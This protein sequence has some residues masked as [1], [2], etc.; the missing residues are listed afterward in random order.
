[1][2][3]HRTL[4]E[5][6]RG[7]DVARLHETL[8]AIGIELD[9]DERAGKQFGPHTRDAVTRIQLVLGL[10]PTGTV[11]PATLE[12][13]LIARDRL[14]VDRVEPADKPRRYVVEGAVTDA[15][16]LPLTGVTV[17][18]YR[19]V[20]RDE[21]EI[22]RAPAD[23]S[24]RYHIEYSSEAL[25]GA[26]PEAEPE[27]EPE[28]D[29]LALRLRVLDASGKV[30]FESGVH[31]HVSRREQI[32]LAVGG[33]GRAEPAEFHR[34]LGA[35]DA[36]LRHMRLEELEESGE[37]RDLTFLGDD[38][39]VGRLAV[40]YHAIAARLAA[41]T[42]LPAELFYALFRENVPADAAVRALAEDAEGTNLDRNAQRLLDAVLSATP[43]IRAKAVA[44]AIEAGV[45]AP[46][47]AE[48]AQDDL[49]RL[50]SHAVDAALAASAGMGKTPVSDVLT[51]AAKVPAD[52]QRV[53]MERWST[54]SGPIREFWSEL[55]DSKAFTTEE[56]A[57]LQFAMTVGRFT[58]GHLPLVSA[59]ADMRAE[60]EITDTRDLARLDAADWRNLIEGGDGR[61][62]VGLPENFTAR[63]DE[64]AL[65]AYTRLL[66]R[67]FERA[68]PTVAF[69]ARLAADA[70]SPFVAKDAVVAFLDAN[71]EFD[72]RKTN[73]DRYLMDKP[74]ALEGDRE[75]VR[76][77]LLTSQRL[78]KLAPR[79]GAAKPLLEAGISSAQ[80]IYSMGASRFQATY[81]P[82]PEIGE[83][84]A[85]RIYSVA[86]QTYAM[87]LTLATQLGATIREINP[88]AIGHPAPA[89][90]APAEG[91]APADAEP[92][93]DLEAFPN[94]RTLFGSLDLC[95]CKHCRSVLSPAAHLTDMLRFLSH[96]V[97]A[98]TSAKQVLLERRP[99]I[100]QIELSCENTNTVLP[101]IDLVN[102]L[103]EDA[104]ASPPDLAAAARARQTTLET[105]ELNANPQY[106]NDGA[107]ATLAAAV[108]PWNLPFDLPLLEAR[109]YLDRLGTDRVRLMRTVRKEPDLG[110]AE[111]SRMAVEALGLSP[112]E[113]DIVIAGPLAASHQPWDYW[114]LA[115]SGN[116]VQDPVETTR[117]YTGTWLEVLSNARILLDRARLTHAELQH[118]LN[119]RF[120]NPGGAVTTSDTCDIGEMT[121]G[122]LT[123]DVL[124][125][126]HRFVR[127]MRRLGWTPNDL[128]AAI[129]QLQGSTPAGAGRLNA[130]LLRQLRAVTAA[131]RRFRI[132]APEAIALLAGIDT[133]AVPPLPGE[134]APRQCLYDQLFQ[135]PAVLNPVD[136][137]FELD[138]ARQEID[139]IAAN[140][141]LADHR[142][143]LVAAF[144]LPDA[145][146]GRAIAEETDGKLTLANL[147][148][149]YRTVLLARGLGLTVEELLVLRDIAEMERPAAPGY[150]PIDPF[151][152]ARPELLER[153]CETVDTV[154]DADLDI[155]QLDYLLRHRATPKSGVALDDVV[156]GTL[157][158][159]MREGLVRI[160]GENAP[161]ADPTGAQVR[162]RL[163]ALMPTAEVEPIMAILAGTSALTEVNQRAAVAGSLG[164]FVPLAEAQAKLVGAAALAA[165]TARYEYVFGALAVHA[166][167]T[168]GT[169]LIVQQLAEA[170][171]LAT[172][173][174]R[175]L[176][177]GWFPS[178]TLP[179]TPMLDQFLLL[180]T[181]ARDPAKQQAPV[182]RD[183]A[184][185]ADY[186]TAYTA[187][188][189]AARLIS[190][191]GFS[192]DEVAWFQGHGVAA[193]WLDP[194]TLPAT[195]TP[196]PEGRF[197]RWLRVA[198]AARLKAAIPGDGGAFGGL[199]DVAAG[200]TKAGHLETIGTRMDWSA[201]DL[202]ALAG[203]RTDATN[204]GLL[205]LAFPDD[206]RSE[207]ALV[208]LRRAFAQLRRLGVPA[209][210]AGEWTG[211]AVSAAQAAAIKQSVKAKYTV[212]QWPEI[213][214]PVRD[215]L[216]ERQRDALVSFLLTDPPP[217]VR[218]WQSPNDV[219]GHYLIDV[220]M[221]ACQ[222]TSRIV[223]ANA[224]IQLFVQRSAL[225]LEPD[226]TVDAAADGHWLEWKWM[227]RYRVWEANRKVFLYPENWIEPGL[228]RDK[229]PFFQDMENELLQGEVTKGTAEA[230][231]RGYL[232]K[233]DAVARL[234]VLGTYFEAG[235]PNR[236]HVIGRKQ[237]DPPT[238]YHR[239]WVDSSR[240]TAW[241]RVELD[242]VSDH[243]LPVAWN[244]R[245]YLFWA[246]VNRRADKTQSLP[247]LTPANSPPPA[248][249]FHLEAQLAWS[250]L[251][252]GKW[253]AKQTAPQTFVVRRDAEPRSVTL[254]SSI[255][256]PL[257]RIDVF[258]ETLHVVLV[259]PGLLAWQ[260]RDHVGEFVLGGVGNSVEAFAVPGE[261]LDGAG[262]G[263]A[264]IGQ[265]APA[266]G[267]GVLPAPTNSDYDGM[268]L[269]PLGT[270]SGG[271][272]RQ[273]VAPC[274]TTYD[275][276]GTLASET[277][278]DRADRY[279]LLIPHQQLRFDSSLPFFYSD[280]QRSYFVIPQRYYQNGN[281]FLTTAPA[282]VYRPN[283]R[284]QYKFAPNYHAFVPLLIRELN[285]GGVDRLY[286]RRLQASP[287]AAQGVPAFDFRTYYQPTDRV[288]APYP[289]EGIDFDYDA[290]YSIYNWEL[291]FHAP[292]QIG[293]SLS[294]N[295]RF[296]EA[297]HFYEYVFDPTSA[298]DEPAPQR[299]WVTKR[300]HD[301]TA[302]EYRAAEIRR[303]MALINVRDPGVEHQVA[304]WR[305]NPFE[306]HV[307]AGLRPVAYQRAIVMKYID[308]LIAW[309]D[310][311]FRQDTMDSVN[312]ATQL[313][314]LAAELLGPRPEIVQPARDVP[315][316]Y[317]DIEAGL[318]TFA[319]AA[320]AAA[321]NAIAPVQVDVAT[322]QG[323]P[324]L[325][326][327]PPL[328]FCVPP[329]EKL[330]AYWDTVG[331]RL[332]KIRHCMNIEGV[333]RQLTLFAPP[334][335]PGL[336]VKAAAAGLDLGSL[337]SDSGSSLPPYRFRVMVREAMQITDSV[338]MLG[339]E[340]LFALEKRDAEKLTL[341]RS[342]SERTLH[343]GL[344]DMRKKGADEAQ[345]QI[346][347]LAK[348]REVTLERQRYFAERKDDLT[349]DWEAAA[350]VLMGASAAAQAVAL[351]LDSASGA[352]HLIPEVQA[353]ASG[354]GGS[355]H[356][357]VK[358]GGP[359]VG[360]G[361]GGFA[362]AA[363]V[364]AALLQTGA[365]MSSVLGGY[366]RRKQEA[367]FQHGLAGKELAVIQAQALTLTIRKTMAENEQANE[368]VVRALAD[369]T[370][371]F[372][373][374]RFTNQELYEW[375]AQ[376]TSATY[377]Q[378]YRLAYA[379]AQQAEACFRRE[380]GV[381][382]TS[383]VQFGYWDSLKK[384]LLAGDKLGFD[385]E[386]METAY[387]SADTRELELTK[388][389]SLLQ[390]D[391]V[392]LVELRTKGECIVTL[393][394]LL[395]DLETPGHYMR[396]LKSVA[397]T[398]P[399][400]TGPYGNVS[401]TATLLDNHVRTSPSAAAPY[402]RA[403]GDDARFT[404]DS[405]GFSA[406]VTSSGQNDPGLFE[407]NHHDERY[408]PFEGAGAIGT[409]KLR[410]NAV[411]PP[412]DYRSISDVIL[413]LRYTARD[414][415]APLA[416][417]AAG[418]VRT[419]LNAVVLAQSRRGLYKLV[420]PKQ[421][422]ASQWHAFLHP[423]VGDDQRLAFDLAPDRFPFFSHGLDLK[424]T[425]IDIYAKLADAGDYSL[426]IGRPGA[427]DE[428][429]TLEADDELGGVHHWGRHPLAPKSGLGRAPATAPHEFSLK[430]KRAGAADF[431]SLAP[432]EVADLSIVFQY[433]A[434]P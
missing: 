35:I 20:L 315:K 256:D 67:S 161:A 414:G 160:A 125:R 397:I 130:L 109:T 78:L 362:K 267:K 185:F 242:I 418:A 277:V 276:Y 431:R 127:L 91:S 8:D 104:V 417:A 347:A 171:S 111:T 420:S 273:R 29:R 298:V 363:K 334:I 212:D 336:L 223:Q 203:D 215:V 40:A 370:D 293:E 359:N 303:L 270:T 368:D 227:S 84:E 143:T 246:I 393:P 348:S 288:I 327:F 214:K 207:R 406:I 177:G 384:G 24:G 15:D 424:V 398:V 412:F 433:E 37:H 324:Q 149:L 345:K 291:F 330:L 419:Q 179:A 258:A 377:F 44:T 106:V 136:A 138:A 46:S 217:G 32:P 263:T 63:D 279:R 240:W 302:P 181:V 188:D 62:P 137:M 236:L 316:T 126:L 58:R 271:S 154:R 250:E 275:Q 90:P 379:V 68:Y 409:W 331:D 5:G 402:M 310:Q 9:E 403:A 134:D 335:D 165:G 432:D 262:P 201:E 241:T 28:A 108:H 151:D 321:E 205:G 286:E 50:A 175:L 183:E 326:V 65:E 128:D 410:L 59:I 226:V 405:G 425:G 148:R 322:P 392:A 260:S 118:V 395:F 69:S 401:L 340:L 121:V 117:A 390:M 140:P 378:A 355:P 60:G 404:D 103:L 352:A 131:M 141:E 170:L 333:I 248:T 295:Q 94:L 224:S 120:V 213:A 88:A 237:G 115:E 97:T 319:N 341:I 36:R 297:K 407:L 426:A 87:A 416:D 339:N 66:E 190:G 311:L 93:P 284:A 38:A 294:L 366:Q 381:K 422:L 26:R 76:E 4:S 343:K 413:H 167:R 150:E 102:E 73:V 142:D 6:M 364:V 100:A 189:K 233:L 300:F 253:Q 42:E 83:A 18:A 200:T 228:R 415:G 21:D 342:S 96:R 156:V 254:K 81:G 280:S 306:P 163:V 39:G 264:E 210:A 358:I 1:M 308:N 423:A 48:R 164:P 204:R 396:R 56:V 251:R 320:I 176:V 354:A 192:A 317:A 197:T 146:I 429:V 153:L 369:D 281:Y 17:V 360:R 11:D 332:F 249:K 195:A 16:G 74:E 346:D 411:H 434:L 272:A 82:H 312:E 43:D 112:L 282:D 296:D 313:Y 376:Q 116:T 52:K 356:V 34:T 85:A 408:L 399:C 19:V 389:A 57:D 325:P 353:G 278:L 25:V 168:L 3:D 23:D 383:Y 290:P 79:Y 400:V 31:H 220:E 367:E 33:P 105:P 155:P 145:D 245:L 71:P 10:D 86:E 80:Q 255:A 211:P 247:N 206:Y 221:S 268:A 124:D 152:P 365:S 380:L 92:A 427:P 119:T 55:V 265:L 191:H 199:L 139:A 202:D 159:S 371:E 229:S 219:Y 232:E 349:N 13:A 133:H 218:R 266:L 95:A 430:I 351:A 45:V 375:M 22:G 234:D 198:E 361:T 7:E 132:G 387:L 421:E 329:N 305:A 328:Y 123:A 157:L 14:G 274:C 304:Q 309:G 27:P 209:S 357:T 135:N 318:D 299:Y 314:I 283:Y 147:S 114:G 388:N 166:R 208:A 244:R 307:V 373:R 122:P 243:V 47:Y 225:G 12:L 144:E 53:F 231:L 292:F 428:V 391:P 49:A 72:A 61:P 64:T 98:G 75:F 385:L 285:A 261:S 174:A 196:T 386:R 182:A 173:T 51:T 239:E 337:L 301:M 77:T 89:P 394:E 158:K 238:F 169:G 193:G 287:A 289:I 41:T 30:L 230:A 172:S 382:D 180:P 222:G 54:A 113:A 235:T 178:V 252:D 374:D 259:Y 269:V 372:L 162:K 338:R 350:L 70:E 216:R 257:L 107:Y 2:P 187:L 344:V 110:S 101:Y 184:G 194:T 99:D 129:E 186:F 323:T